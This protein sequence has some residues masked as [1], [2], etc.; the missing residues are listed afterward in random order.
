[1]LIDCRSGVWCVNI[2]LHQ[3]QPPPGTTHSLWLRV[4]HDTETDWGCVCA[5]VFLSFFFLHAFLFEVCCVGLDVCSFV[6]LWP[7]ECISVCGRNRPCWSRTERIRDGEAERERGTQRAVYR[8]TVV[9]HY[10]V[11]IAW[12]LS[13]ACPCLGNGKGHQHYKVSHLAR[14]KTG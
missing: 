6:H 14:K 4:R 11:F 13:L 9:W 8:F 5:H 7:N 1:M 10:Y 2:S 3:W 12:L